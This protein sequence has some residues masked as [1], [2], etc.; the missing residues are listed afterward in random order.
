MMLGAGGAA[1]AAALA[2]AHL[3]VKLTVINR[4]PE[5]A[6]RLSGLVVSAVPAA[7]CDWLPLERLDAD[8]V[9]RQRL[10]LNATS[11]GMDGAGKV[12]AALADTVTAEQV[13]FDV[14]YASDET[15]F[16][17]LARARGATVIGGLEMLVHQAAA[18]FELWTGRS[19]PL[20]VMRDATQQR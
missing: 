18:A 11:L 13:V 14:V 17:A 16:L 1:R 3:G 2:L 20:D 8:L 4:T 12:P 15:E 6:A 5:A 9:R 19:A 10:V 7:R